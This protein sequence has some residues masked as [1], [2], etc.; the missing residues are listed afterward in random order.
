MGFD[1]AF[2]PVVVSVRLLGVAAGDFDVARIAA[3]VFARCAEAAT[4]AQIGRDVVVSMENVENM[5]IKT[6]K[7]VFP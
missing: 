6:K 3:N 2:R 5:E 1:E 7:I 4:T